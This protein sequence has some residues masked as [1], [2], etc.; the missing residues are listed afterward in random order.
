MIFAKQQSVTL[1]SRIAAGN[2]AIEK[3]RSRRRD[4][5]IKGDD[6]AR[7]VIEDE[8]AKA[9][10]EATLRSERREILVSEHE[11]ALERDA[12]E[13]FSRRHAAQSE[14]NAKIAAAAQKALRKAWDILAP[15]L[16]ELSEARAATDLLNRAAPEGF[17]QLPYA[18]DLARGA[19]ALP[20]IEISSKEVD[21]WAFRSTGNRVGDQDAVQGGFLPIGPHE[22]QSNPCVKRRYRH[23][24]FHPAE[25]A[26]Y[27]D[28]I[29]SQLRF[30]RWD[31]AGVIFDGS[32]VLS[33]TVATVLDT[34]E[35]DQS[36]KAAR[37]ILEEFIPTADD[38]LDAA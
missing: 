22:L 16:R 31:E 20:R 4:A 28:P 3:L 12:R 30:P 36:R 7:T 33:G 25:S 5:I 2:V 37:P 14:T 23:V 32:F 9:E 13:E 10:R 26:R 35:A 15:S 6:A 17:S 34:I 18:D 24:R 27:A 8:I 38:A 11:A 29:S 19:P 1:T 21:Q